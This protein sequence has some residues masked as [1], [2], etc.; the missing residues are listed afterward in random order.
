MGA[1]HEFISIFKNISFSSTFPI[2]KSSLEID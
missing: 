1:L 2:T